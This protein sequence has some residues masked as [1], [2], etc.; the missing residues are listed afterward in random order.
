MD[1]I[2]Y[3]CYADHIGYSFPKRK[4]W[5]KA[6]VWIR[7]MRTC[8][9]REVAAEL[10]ETFLGRKVTIAVRILE[11]PKQMERSET[12]KDWNE[13][14]RV[15]IPECFYDE[16]CQEFIKKSCKGKR[17]ES[18][19]IVDLQGGI[20][21]ETV[22]RAV[23]D[24]NYLAVYTKNPQAYEGILER[25]EQETGLVGMLFTDQREW[26]QYQKLVCGKEKSLILLG[27][28]QKDPEGRITP[29]FLHVPKD[30]LLLDLRDDTAPEGAFLIK[31]KGK[32]GSSLR[33]YLDNIV[34]NGYNSL[35]N[36]GMH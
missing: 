1:K 9:Q 16:V 12:A 34:K 15:V 8:R 28:A 32:D 23:E 36:E 25:I 10:E 29:V 6:A 20:A 3:T 19:L 14:F 35:V 13:D 17:F 27:N 22:Y 18:L 31:R 4:W 21:K 2:I 24:R 11:R 26:K 30:A 33:S 7:L 5:E